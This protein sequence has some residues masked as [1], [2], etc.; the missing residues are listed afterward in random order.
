MSSVYPGMTEKYMRGLSNVSSC[1]Y[2]D[3]V[4]FYPPKQKYFRESFPFSHSPASFK[5]QFKLLPFGT[6]RRVNNQVMSLNS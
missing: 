4:G 1:H 3:I 5:I 6:K 2:L